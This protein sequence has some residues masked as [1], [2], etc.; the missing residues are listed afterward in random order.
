MERR[1]FLGILTLG[2]IGTIV[3][4]VAL[5]D[6]EK[7]V[8]E[9]LTTDTKKLLIEKGAIEKY[10]V[11]AK[12]RNIYKR[13]GFGKKEFIRGHYFIN[14]SIFTL[15]Y[16]TKYSRYRSEIVG[17]FLLSTDFF[18]NKMTVEKEVKYLSFYDPYKRPC[19][20]PFSNVY[21]T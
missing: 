11:D 7:I 9:I 13:F 19:N 16:Y 21:Y 1:K 3:G 17:S 18:I 15:P 6:F 5:P 20:N 2:A 12:N 14:N 8:K 4:V 10:L